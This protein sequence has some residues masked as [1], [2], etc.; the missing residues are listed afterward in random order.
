MSQGDPVVIVGAGLAGLCC[1]LGLSAAGV[2]CQIVEAADDVGGRVRTDFVEG[3]LLDRGFQVLLTAY[4]E[5]RRVLDYD[6]LNLQSFNS[7]AIVRRNGSFNKLLFPLRHPQAMVSAAISPVMTL[8]D[9]LRALGLWNSLRSGDAESLLNSGSEQTTEDE[10]KAQG[11]SP[12]AIESFFRP[13]FGGVFL[14]PRLTTSSRFFR[15]MFR[16]FAEG[17]AAVPEQ[18][19]AQIPQQL[20]ARVKAAGVTIQLNTRVTDLT[21]TRVTL[22]DGKILS[23]S[24]VVVAAE[25]PEAQRLIGQDLASGAGAERSACTLY[26]AADRPCV[27]EPTLVLNGDGAAGGPLN[28]L[29]EMSSVAGSYAPQGATLISAS[30]LDSRGMNDADLQQAVVNQLVGWYGRS[31]R[32][33]RHLRT[34]WISHALPPLEPPTLQNPERSVRIGR[35]LF[36][37]GDHR[38]QA[39]IQGAFNSGRRAAEAVISQLQAANGV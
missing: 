23:A 12:T 27:G 26:F 29:A 5:A 2:Q 15:F 34:Y 13:F 32:T 6:R 8:G 38:D 19:M 37:C 3:F 4:P 14:Q 11:F 10:L 7:G 30:V 28:H 22:A 18:G 36:A 20:A 31:V 25:L 16:M 9:K 33:W 21:P 17:S 39:S 24:A 35:G 1:A